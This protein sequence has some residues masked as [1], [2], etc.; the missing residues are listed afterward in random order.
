MKATFIPHLPNKDVAPEMQESISTVPEETAI[1]PFPGVTLPMQTPDANLMHIRHQFP[2]VAVMPFPYETVAAV[3]VKD[4]AQD[5]TVPD[6][7]VIGR[8]IG[9]G[10]YWVSHAQ[11]A[12]VPVAGEQ[13][14][15]MFKPEFTYF[16]LG[17]V[18]QFS[19]VSPT[20]GTVVQLVTYTADKWPRPENPMNI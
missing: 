15:S 17:G 9:N 14:Q 16:Y 18:K 3:M 11:R 5:I 6:G 7:A 10:D 12:K 19:V 2:F 20:D 13:S 8:F 4:V 1:F